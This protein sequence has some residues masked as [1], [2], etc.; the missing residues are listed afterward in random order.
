MDAVTYPTE[1]VV[2]FITESLIPLR[3]PSD[4]EPLATEFKIKWTP[5]LIV[6]DWNGKEHSRT[7]GFL[8]PEE[9]IPSLLL[10]IAKTYYELDMFPEALANLEKVIQGYRQSAAMPEAIFYR[11]VCLYK[12]SHDPKPLKQAY[13]KLQADYPQSEWT[14]RALPYRLLP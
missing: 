9:F 6:L 4:S 12:S 13:E 2:Q 7:V 5:A 3:I 11:G 10:G 8:T 14:K 1:S